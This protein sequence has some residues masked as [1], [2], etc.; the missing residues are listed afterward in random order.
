M[1]DAAAVLQNFF[2][3]LDIQEPAFRNVVVL[4][5]RKVA[6]KV[7]RKSEYEPI[8]THNPVRPN[9]LKTNRSMFPLHRVFSVDL[10]SSI[11]ISSHALRSLS[12][13]H[14]VSPIHACPAA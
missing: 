7:E 9:C 2:K 10:E 6:D 1:P 3:P 4:Y 13:F 5:R 11:L 14:I 8:R 12:C